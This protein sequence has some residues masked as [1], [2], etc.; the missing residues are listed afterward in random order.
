MIKKEFIETIKN[1]KNNLEKVFLN[2]LSNLDLSLEDYDLYDLSFIASNETSAQIDKIFIKSCSKW[3]I[4]DKFKKIETVFYKDRTEIVES[5]VWE[6]YDIHIFKNQD[7]KKYYFA[8]YVI[9]ANRDKFEQFPKKTTFT[10]LEDV[11]LTENNM[12]VKHHFKR[13]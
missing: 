5:I 1:F 11:D 13:L 10:N 7:D 9:D 12:N 3:Q 6:I 2:N 8:Y 4:G